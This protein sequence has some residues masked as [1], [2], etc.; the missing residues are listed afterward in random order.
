MDAPIEETTVVT[1][2]FDNG[3]PAGWALYGT[4]AVEG[5]QVVLTPNLTSLAGSIFYA[6]PVPNCSGFNV[7]FDFEIDGFADGFT[8]AW[9][10]GPK[11]LNP[12]EGATLGYEDLGGYAVEFD[13]YCD[14][15][16]DPPRPHIALIKN[17]VR[18]HLAYSMDFPTLNNSGIFS[19]NIVFENS[20]IRVYLSNPGAGL[21]E[22]KLVLEHTISGYEPFTAYLGLTGATGGVSARHAIDNVR[23]SAPFQVPQKRM[24][25]EKKNGKRKMTSQETEPTHM[26]SS[27]QLLRAERLKEQ[28]KWDEA[29]TAYTRLADQHPENIELQKAVVL[30]LH[31]EYRIGKKLEWASD[32]FRSYSKTIKRYAERVIKLDPSERDMYYFGLRGYEYAGLPIAETVKRQLENNYEQTRQRFPDWQGVYGMYAEAFS[33][34]GL[35]DLALAVTDDWANQLGESAGMLSNRSRALDGLGRHEEAY[36]L[37]LDALDKFPE[38]AWL[39][40]HLADMELAR[41]NTTRAIELY[42]EAHNIIP[43]EHFKNKIREIRRQRAATSEKAAAVT[44]ATRRDTG[45]GAQWPDIRV[46]SVFRPEQSGSY[47]SIIEMNGRRRFAKEGDEFSGLRVLR[48]DG[49]DNCITVSHPSLGERQ[50][51]E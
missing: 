51:C 37:A 26:D 7:S 45:E 4:A 14:R 13:V 33:N 42:E 12:R 23:M 25:G 46:K 17:D 28:G 38:D 8:F 24:K 50:Y 27:L 18:E 21:P 20:T 10:P 19:C 39:A 11:F 32:P 5:G 48:V 22:K 35:F 41:G 9:I 2:E 3:L 30:F 47:I 49:T 43:N 16:Y 1:A 15:Y 34:L 40:A 44:P 36:Q 6:A 31:N 29:L